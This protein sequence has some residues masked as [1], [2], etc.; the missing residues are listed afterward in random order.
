MTGLYN[1]VLETACL[2]QPLAKVRLYEDTLSSRSG[3][4]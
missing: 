2:I 4:C 3:P 1:D